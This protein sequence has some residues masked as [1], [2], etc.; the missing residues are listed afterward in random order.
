MTV[1]SVFYDK[2]YAC[3]VGGIVGDAMGAPGEGKTYQEIEAASGWVSDFQGAG[4]DD[5]VV[6]HILS[7]AIIN[8]GGY[9]TA[10]EFAVAFANNADKFRV[11]YTPVRNQFCLTTAGL[12]LPVYAGMG[13]QQS[14]S[15][16]MAIAPMG[17]LN[18]C[19]PRQAAVETYDVAGLIHGQLAT[20]CRDG[21]CAI[22]A[23][24]AEAF[25]PAATVD[26][27]VDAATRYLHPISS[28]E[29]R[30]CIESALAL[31]HSEGEYRAFRSAFYAK[32]L[33]TEAPTVIADSRETVPCTLALLYL[34]K[35][36]PRLAITYAANFGRDADTIACMAGGI[37]SALHG[38]AAVGMDW[39]G[40]VTAA[41]PGQDDLARK[42]VDVA[43]SKA[44]HAHEACETLMG[45]N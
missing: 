17:I 41:V 6:K 23:A 31:A 35:G 30:R 24:V 21:A 37:S 2:A 43:I 8:S 42:L 9:P 11:F 38:T 5:T 22:A 34:A 39:I 36:D 12:V 26:S 25:K 28:A 7:E 10:D 18:A 3:L 15:S 20:A 14:S 19:N 1:T 40:K 27:V 44:R 16:A 45:T 33:Y 13:G 32:H 4:T 29:L